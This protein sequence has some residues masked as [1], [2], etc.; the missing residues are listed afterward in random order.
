MSGKSAGPENMHLIGDLTCT[1]RGL[2]DPEVVER[3]MRE[4]IAETGLHIEHFHLQE[5]PNG[6]EFGAGITGMALL[7]ESHMVVHTA[8][9]RGTLNLDLFS[10]RPFPLV[11]VVQL[12]NQA[13][14][15]IGWT[16][17]ET[18]RR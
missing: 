17:W 16:R 4:V 2:A 8:P 6:S 13:F 14:A 18:L 9:E 3:F 15:P 1:S 5:F 11:R 10:C 12:L 7:S